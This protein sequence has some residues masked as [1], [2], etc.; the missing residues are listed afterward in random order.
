MTLAYREARPEDAE[1]ASDVMTAA[2]P[3]LPQDPVMTR[4]RWK[5][6]RQRFA[7]GR[8]FAALDG[9]DVA[10]LAWLHG[11]WAEVADGH[12]EVEVWLD[13]A[14]LD[15]DLLR[16]MWTWIG[17]RAAADGARL[18]L[19]YAAEDELEALEVLDELGYDRVRLEKVW[20]LDLRERGAGIVREAEAARERMAR[21][22]ITMTTVA[23]WDDPE[24]LRKLHAL[25]ASTVQDVPHSV[26]IV[27]EPL[28]E[29]VRRVNAPDRPHDRFW[30]AL[31][32]DV[33]IAMSYLK[34]PPVRGT[35]WT[36]YTCTAAAYRGRGIARAVKLQS[37]AQAV[38][39]GVPAVCTDNDSENGPMLRINETLGYRRRPGFVEHH[40]R[41]TK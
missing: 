2:Y 17:D 27:P 26:V 6:W 39:L 29:F 10:F 11:P 41:V 20:D 7:A 12:C 22:G 36:G 4:L 34:F 35:I 37:L 1:H 33:P 28:D 3:P 18:L 16:G 14:V 40:K 32:G 31:D 19:A 21:D 30:V 9:R 5:W 38:E 8:F 24:K 15:R 23:A 25:N 13:R